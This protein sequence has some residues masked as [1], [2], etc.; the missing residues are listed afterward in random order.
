MNKSIL[1]VIASLVAVLGI[2]Q[3]N[4]ATDLDSVVFKASAGTQ[5]SSSVFN[6]TTEPTEPP[7]PP[8]PP[9]PPKP[10]KPKP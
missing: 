10:K 4:A 1:V 6:E 5:L 8:V 3:T 7:K 9:K 2:N